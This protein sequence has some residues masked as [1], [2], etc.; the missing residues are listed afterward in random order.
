MNDTLRRTGGWRRVWPRPAGRN[1]TPS[2]LRTS[3]KCEEVERVMEP[4]R[5]GHPGL[6]AAPL[7]ADSRPHRATLV[8]PEIPD[9]EGHRRGSKR[10]PD[11]R[12]RHPR[13]ADDGRPRGLSGR[14][15]ASGARAA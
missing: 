1:G 8:A 2:Y 6:D 9:E 3:K 10:I 4:R 7:W 11:L 14:V 5:P 15:R 12:R 13:G